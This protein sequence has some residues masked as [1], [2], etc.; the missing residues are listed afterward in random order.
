MSAPPP[1]ALPRPPSLPILPVIAPPQYKSS[2]I[3]LSQSAMFVGAL[4]STI[5]CGSII[6]KYIQYE[7]VRRPPLSLLFWRTVADLLFA[8]QYLVTFFVQMSM[9]NTQR[10]N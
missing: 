6:V 3:V 10:L 1:P 4:I 8:L 7:S 9:N 5:A 2:S